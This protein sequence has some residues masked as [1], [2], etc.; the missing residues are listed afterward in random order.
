MGKGYELKVKVTRVFLDDYLV[1][2]SM[3]IQA[4][5]SMAEAL[6]KLI[7]RQLEPSPEEVVAPKPT[8]RVKVPMAFLVRPQP[9]IVT[10]G[11]KTGIFVIKPKGGVI[12]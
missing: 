1:L 10:N 2:K 5:I 8:Y 7:T 3:S 11:H 4:G 12:Q 6:H 9:I